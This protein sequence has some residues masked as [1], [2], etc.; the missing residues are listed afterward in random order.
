MKNSKLIWA[1]LA[2]LLLPFQSFATNMPGGGDYAALIGL[3]GLIIG[4]VIATIAF[5]LHYF[6]AKTKFSSKKYFYLWLAILLGVPVILEL[7]LFI[8]III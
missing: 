3:G 7:F 1:S 6:I 4:F 8:I 2:L 5:F